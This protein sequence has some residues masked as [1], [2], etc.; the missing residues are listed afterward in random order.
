MLDEAADAATAKDMRAMLS[1][2]VGV[3]TTKIALHEV[4]CGDD[5][6]LA[7]GPPLGDRFAIASMAT[8]SV[9]VARIG[10][11]SPTMSTTEFVL[12]A[13]AEP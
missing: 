10:A 7:F 13:G 2:K 9:L 11:E 1:H 3:D 5:G 8:E 12:S 6:E 4:T